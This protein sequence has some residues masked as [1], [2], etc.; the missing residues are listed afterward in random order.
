MSTD[1]T[2]IWLTKGS[3]TI[4]SANRLIQ[5]AALLQLNLCHVSKMIVE[6]I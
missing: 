5:F 3:K 1:D 2:E 4:S 6:N